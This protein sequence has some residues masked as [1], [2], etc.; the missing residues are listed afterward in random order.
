MFPGAADAWAR[1]IGWVITEILFSRAGLWLLL[2]AACAALGWFGGGALDRLIGGAGLTPWLLGGVLLLGALF[3]FHWL[4]GVGSY[5]RYEEGTTVADLEDEAD[6][7][8]HERFL[9]RGR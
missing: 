3:L 4:L 6:L 9:R 8:L 1:L 7:S 2:S 5:Q